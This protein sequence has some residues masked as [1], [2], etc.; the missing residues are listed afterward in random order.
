MQER[1]LSNDEASQSA[2]QPHPRDA[3]RLYLIVLGGRMIKSVQVFKRTSFDQLRCGGV[4]QHP[5][6]REGS[7]S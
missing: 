3:L 4:A 2:C 6:L 5:C 1:I 7:A